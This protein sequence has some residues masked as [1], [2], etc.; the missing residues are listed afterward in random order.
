M[1]ATEKVDANTQKYFRAW[2]Q[3]S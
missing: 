1:H 3:G 2:S